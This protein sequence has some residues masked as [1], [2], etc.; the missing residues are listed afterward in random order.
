[1]ETAKKK[2]IIIVDEYMQGIIDLPIT[3]AEDSKFSGIYGLAHYCEKVVLFSGAHSEQLAEMTAKFFP[4]KKIDMQSE[5]ESLAEMTSVGET[6][7][8]KVMASDSVDKRNNKVANFL[9]EKGQ[10]EIP[11]MIF[12]AD[13]KLRTLLENQGK[14]KVQDVADRKKLTAIQL[15]AKNIRN[16]VVLMHKNY[17]CGIDLN[18][19]VN[20]KVVII[21]EDELP[22]QHEFLQKAGRAQRGK[23]FPVCTVFSTTG[24]GSEIGAASRIM[25]DYKTPMYQV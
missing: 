19:S 9:N 17:G 14:R 6:Q 2:S 15:I 8:V 5:Y 4:N 13:S 22:K 3:F 12:G 23:Y 11:I 24:E 16:D 18:F 25:K 10:A 7:T 21:V 1:M 20:C